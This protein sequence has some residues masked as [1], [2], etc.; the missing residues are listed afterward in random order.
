MN[1]APLLVIFRLDT[2][3]YGL[4]LSGVERVIRAVE[5]TPL[6]SA[7]FI[8]LGVID[9]GGR[10]LPVLNLRRRLR[11]P[12]REILPGDQFVVAHTTSRTVVLVVDEALEVIDHEH[13]DL[14]E[15]HEITPGLEYVQGIVQ[16]KDGLVFIHD[17]ESFLSSDEGRRLDSALLRSQA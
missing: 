9:L 15:S 8:V 13:G 12:E 1:Q 10:I 14:I 11:L 5:V 6:P 4:E 17:L 16:L 7:P 2:Q 3:R